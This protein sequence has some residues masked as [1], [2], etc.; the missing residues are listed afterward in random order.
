MAREVDYLHQLN[1]KYED[2]EPS[3]RLRSVDNLWLYAFGPPVTD[4]SLPVKC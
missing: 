4:L 2:L 3:N 1:L